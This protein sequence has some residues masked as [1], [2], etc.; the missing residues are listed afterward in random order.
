KEIF[1]REIP[2]FGVAG[3]QHAAMVGQC[4]F[5][6]GDIKSTYGTGC[7]A[8]VNTGGSILNS[9]NRLLSTIAYGYKGKIHYA[10]E[11][12]I[13]V[14]GAAIQWLRDDL[15]LLDHAAES[16]A[17]AAGLKHNDGVYFV[18]AFTG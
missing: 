11:G 17:M 10:L 5:E 18:P 9:N 2:I 16:A 14:A 8:L 3:D 4:C 6:V 1:G 15:K 12:S 13:F 7:F